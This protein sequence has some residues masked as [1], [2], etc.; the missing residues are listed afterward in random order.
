MDISVYREFPIK[1][2]I[3][4]FMLK[5]TVG[6]TANINYEEVEKEDGKIS[7]KVRLNHFNGIS[8]YQMILY[9]ADENGDFNLNGYRKDILSL[10][11]KNLK[12]IR[13]KVEKA[14]KSKFIKIYRFD[15]SDLLPF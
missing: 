1:K 4:D 13:D 12:K 6:V 7:R 9:K 15:Q 8:F 2:T 11:D 14:I 10:E 5:G 3:D